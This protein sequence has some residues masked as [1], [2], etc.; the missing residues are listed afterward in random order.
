MQAEAG[1]QHMN[2]SRMARGLAGASFLLA[3]GTMIFLALWPDFYQGEA[4]SPSGR[5]LE[6]TSS[7]LIEKNG[8][9]VLLWLLLPV[10]LCFWAFLASFWESTAA[11]IAMWTMGLVVLAFGWLSALSIGPFY[12]PAALALIIAAA[13]AKTVPRCSSA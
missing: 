11:K 13:T 3:L 7:S 8:V 4:V 12:V 6:K 9:D 1:C 10:A 5:V 2:R